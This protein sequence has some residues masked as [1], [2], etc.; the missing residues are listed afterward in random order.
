[1]WEKS[2]YWL[3]CLDGVLHETSQTKVHSPLQ[4]SPAIPALRLLLCADMC[5]FVFVVFKD[6]HLAAAMATLPV[7]QTNEGKNKTVHHTTLQHYTSTVE[8]V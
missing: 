4:I 7:V 2:E 3:L 6:P 1:M 5:I 8:H